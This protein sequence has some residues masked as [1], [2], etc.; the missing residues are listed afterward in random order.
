MRRGALL[1]L[2]LS[3]IA[4]WCG[5]EPARPQAAEPE[6]RYTA[7]ARGEFLA[8]DSDVTAPAGVDLADFRP[9]LA[10]ATLD[11]NA[12]APERARSATVTHPVAG[13]VDQPETSQAE[14]AGGQEL[15]DTKLPGFHNGTSSL[16]LPSPGPPST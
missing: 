9:V 4:L 14:S 16:V 13:V 15:V 10:E 11:P 12:P 3:S 8:F 6:T 5:L 2:T 7:S 1:L